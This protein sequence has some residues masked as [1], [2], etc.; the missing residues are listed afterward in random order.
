MTFKC[1][2]LPLILENPD[3]PRWKWVKAHAEGCPECRNEL[4]FWHELSDSAGALHREWETPELWPRIAAALEVEHS[5]PVPALKVSAAQAVRTWWRTAAAVL[6]TAVGL[7]ALW[8][9]M[10]HFGTS[11]LGSDSLL[12]EAALARA[13]ASEA[14]YLESMA[15]LEQAVQGELEIPDSAVAAGCRERLLTIDDAAAELREEIEHNR[16]NVGLRSALLSVY[17][18]REKTLKELVDY[19]KRSPRAL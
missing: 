15:R 10:P 7:I 2:D 14:E 12:S 16:F 13:E 4:E 11:E 6:L 19:V 17:E 5:K 3:D 1:A 18:A 8:H 9:L